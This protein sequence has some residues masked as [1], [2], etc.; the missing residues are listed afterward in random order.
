MGVLFTTGDAILLQRG[1][2]GSLLV[3]G[4]SSDRV[5][6]HT[7]R[8]AAQMHVNS[9]FQGM[10][11]QAE[12]A[13]RLTTY[14]IKH[15]LTQYYVCRLEPG[16]PVGATAALPPNT[17]WHSL[18]DL[19]PA[20]LSRND[21]RIL[22]RRVADAYVRKGVSP[23]LEA[24]L[25]AKPVEVTWRPTTSEAA[26]ALSAEENS[27][28]PS[29]H[30]GH[31]TASAATRALRAACL[32]DPQR[33]LSIDLEG[34]LRVGGDISC[35]QVSATSADGDQITHVFDIKQHDAPLTGAAYDEEDEHSLR[36]LLTDAT[37]VKVLHCGRGDSNALWYNFGI[38]MENV[39][40]TSI[41]DSLLHATP[42][43]K[44]RGLAKV[45]HEWAGVELQLKDQVDHDEGRA[46]DPRPLT[47]LLF[48]Y[49]YDD[50]L[51][52]RNVYI[53]MH[54][55][56]AKNNMLQLATTYAIQ[57]CPPLCWPPSHPYSEPP[58]TMIVALHDGVRAVTFAH[59]TADAFMPGGPMT[60][61]HDPARPASRS[62][63]TEL[64]VVARDH[65]ARSV[66]EPMGAVKPLLGNGLRRPVRLGAHYVYE[67]VSSVPLEELV[68]PLG[69]AAA[70]LSDTLDVH[71]PY[72]ADLSAQRE[73]G[74]VS[75]IAQYLIHVTAVAAA[76]A[77]P[78]ATTEVTE[79]TALV[80]NAAQPT[81]AALLLHDDTH[82]IVM[83]HPSLG[84]IVPDVLIEVG[85]R[86]IDAALRA[87]HFHVG[88]VLD[89]TIAPSLHDA[90]M[91]AVANPQILTVYKDI[92]VLDCHVRLDRPLSDYRL[93]LRSAQLLAQRESAR[94]TVLFR[95]AQ[96]APMV[97]VREH[98]LCSP[99][100]KH[101]L[102]TPL[103][104]PADALEPPAAALRAAAPVAPPAPVQPTA[105]S[106]TVPTLQSLVTQ[107]MAAPCTSPPVSSTA[108][109]S[110]P[111]PA[112][113]IEPG[114][115]LTVLGAAGETVVSNPDTQ[116]THAVTWTHTSIAL[117]PTTQHAWAQPQTIAFHRAFD[118]FVSEVTS[119]RTGSCA[120]DGAP[121]TDLD[122]SPAQGSCAKDG[123]KCRHS[124]PHAPHARSQPHALTP[125]RFPPLGDT[126]TD[127]TPRATAPAAELPPRPPAD[128]KQPTPPQDAHADRRTCQTP[129]PPPHPGVPQPRP[130]SAQ[131]EGEGRGESTPK[132]P[133]EP[134]PAN[135]NQPANG[136]A[137]QERTPAL[138][139]SA[140]EGI[141][142]PPEGLTGLWI[143]QR[144]ATVHGAPLATQQREHDSA[145]AGTPRKGLEDVIGIL[146]GASTLTNAPTKRE[147]ERQAVIEP[148]AEPP[149]ARDAP[150]HASYTHE[151]DIIDAVGTRPITAA[152]KTDVLIEE[153]KR[154]PYSSMIY[155]FHE[156]G[157]SHDWLASAEVGSKDAF[158]K[159][160]DKFRLI[161]GMLCFLDVENAD[162]AP[163]NALGGKPRVYVPPKFREIFL[164]RYHVASNHAGVARMTA[165]MSCWLWWPKLGKAI[166]RHCRQCH[167][168]ARTKVPRH[169]AGAA[170]RVEDGDHPWDVIVVDLYEYH[171]VDGY[172]HV[173]VICD[174]FARGLELVPCKGV[175]NSEEVCTAIWHRVVR[176]HR[177][178]PRQ[179]RSDAG[180]IFISALC[181]SF[182]EAY[183]AELKHSTAEH[184]TTVGLAERTNATLHDALVAHRIASGDTRWYL[185]V[186]HIEV[187]LNNQVNAT[188]GYSPT[189]VEFGRD[190]RGPDDV[191]FFGLRER[192]RSAPQYVQE[193]LSH[194][195]AVWDV[196][197]AKLGLHA[198]ARKR[199][200]D[201]H[202]DV[203]LKFQVH[204][205][206]LLRRAPGHPKWE[207]PFHGP[208]RIAEVLDDDNYKLRDLHSRRLL[209]DV[210]VERL[211]PYP[212]LTNHGDIA[213][214]VDEEF[215]QRIVGRKPHSA[216]DGFLY[217]VR[218][219]GSTPKEDS[220]LTLEQ[221]ANCHDLVRE[222][223]RNINPLSEPPTAPPLE[224][225]VAESPV[226]PSEAARGR[227]HFRTHV[228][229]EDAGPPSVEEVP[230]D[231][232]PTPTTTSTPDSSL[233]P[234]TTLDPDAPF[235]IDDVLEARRKGAGHEILVQWCN[236]WTPANMLTARWQQE[237]RA[238]L[239]REQP[240]LTI[241]DDSSMPQMKHTYDTV[242]E[243]LHVRMGLDMPEAQVAWE[244][245]WMLFSK[246]P[247]ALR[248][249]ARQLITRLS[250]KDT[251]EPVEP[252]PSTL[253]SPSGWPSD[254]VAA[255]AAAT[256]I[257]AAVRALLARIPPTWNAPPSFNR[258]DDPTAARRMGDD[259]HFRVKRDG[260]FVY[261]SEVQLSAAE[262]RR[263]RQMLRE[264]GLLSM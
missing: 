131:G 197:R 218:W 99:L 163:E 54:E 1:V 235:V 249:D 232:H 123:G 52:L 260:L 248:D 150:E 70:R 18:E 221:L 142:S 81:R 253:V 161:D 237:V 193:H 77:R 199:E 133:S 43:S 59:G 263:S 103:A 223:N 261:C 92:A 250:L 180:S 23:R 7:Y 111:P 210:N 55:A 198:L 264:L 211:T 234:V 61:T 64:R 200:R 3:P 48:R 39:F 227:K 144:D 34:R 201:M 69:N 44:P 129:P 95:N 224:P 168:C 148:C 9:L 152:P 62:W 209:E 216:G 132:R 183:G 53:S 179:V 116:E 104:W 27:K 225:I 204:D 241:P 185:Y 143:E 49:A 30:D 50:V 37:I 19:D 217:K 115:G 10:S 257:Q 17:E 134:I 215:V 127:D 26:L 130:G 90:A 231:D 31:D 154:D 184:H 42:L 38:R 155:Q 208:Y 254:R 174:A 203:H 138:N 220:W 57:A 236:T 118:T 107:C 97:R 33:V 41:A 79:P 2:D 122:T 94:K 24:I 162:D 80:T 189:Y 182:W 91:R 187:A 202:R 240:S 72:L 252:P 238:R 195:H 145:T 244:P 158:V 109:P 71:I 214:S 213:P 149:S 11:P 167:V 98:V 172:D 170:H 247:E 88:A 207:E 105:V 128:E 45:L 205:R 114:A 239:A 173:L 93:T 243:I 117:R 245:E 259:F 74:H 56:L 29:L 75:L 186:G 36:S 47:E 63:H 100:L 188:T 192:H 206:V 175:P 140:D 159:K 89:P 181:Q 5:G 137:G 51:Y 58:T 141:A 35:I 233:V 40:D 87:L 21:D 171:E 255:D 124:E 120:K 68:L 112:R 165:L 246:L 82:A 6:A 102:A 176:G 196:V 96:I 251:A 153:Q 14:Y 8:A 15:G 20:S 229:R 25:N 135:K 4:G 139:D 191:A 230:T 222:Y 65:W 46:W 110:A 60:M 125:V 66:G 121:E 119:P 84:Y 262:R 256:H 28:G 258:P 169:M 85:Q 12:A 147:S 164:H 113:V 146:K 126:T 156:S 190:G 178:T 157:R 22:A 67:C 177:T 86:P 32:S 106:D 212:T 16:A 194:L 101:A 83:E 13:L 242:S 166:R 228:H 151:D 219:R 73:A 76:K 78:P 136:S 108:A 226:E 160:A